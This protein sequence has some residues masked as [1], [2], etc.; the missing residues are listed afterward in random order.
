MV[1]TNAGERRR[2]QK[3]LSRN[4]KEGEGSWMKERGRGNGEWGRRGGCSW[5]GEV[6]SLTD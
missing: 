5:G 6:E 3:N 2:I 4:E 1:M